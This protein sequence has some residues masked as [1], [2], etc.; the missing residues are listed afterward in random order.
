MSYI[1]DGRRS[2]ELVLGGEQI[3][4]GGRGFFVEPTIFDEVQPDTRI[5]V[6]E[7]FGP[8]LAVTPFDLSLQALDKFTALKTTW[9]TYRP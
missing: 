4:G 9:I 8:V 6:E 3:Q 1:E 7:I 5:A 2:A